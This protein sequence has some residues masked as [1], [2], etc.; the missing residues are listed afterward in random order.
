MKSTKCDIVLVPICSVLLLLAPA[1][2]QTKKNA[3]QELIIFHAGSLAI[4]FD[5]IIEGFKKENPDVTVLR[6][7][8]GSREEVRTLDQHRQ[9]DTPRQD[10]PLQT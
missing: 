2:S 3:N 7:I 8:A 10:Q 6:E 1:G 4:P 9:C 5:K